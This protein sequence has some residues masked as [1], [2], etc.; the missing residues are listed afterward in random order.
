MKKTKT[1]KV[2]VI[3]P[4]YNGAETIEQTVSIILNS[5][6]QNLEILLVDD[7]SKDKS[8]EVCRKLQEKDKRVLVL[9][10]ENGGVASARN[11]GV[12]SA[13][14][15]YLCFCDQDD[16]V[17]AETYARMIARMEDE[18]SDICICGTGRSVEGQ[19]SAFELSED[20][21][22]EGKSISENLIYPIVFKG[23]N[24]PVKMS[25]ISRYPTIWNCMFRR[26]FWDKYEFQFRSYVNFEDDL[27]LKLDALSRA[28]RVSSIAYTG[29]YWNVNLKSET[30]AHKFVENLAEKQQLYYEDME[31][32]VKRCTKEK[33][34]LL[35]F[36]QVMR[37]K[38]YL[39]AIHILTS[40]QKK[41]DLAYIRTFCKK[42]IF[43]KDF[44][45]GIS[46]RKYVAKGQI[47]AKV[48]LPLLAKKL[49]LTSYMTEKVLDYVLWIS[50]HSQILTKLERKLKGK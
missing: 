6:Y 20:A 48:L 41:K 30:Y 4:V 24:V 15:E 16:F 45:A 43:E 47:R 39:D 17:E 34:I 12:A 5:T 1:G 19:K 11:F 50:L 44:A 18:I 27:L 32:S 7:G 42:T 3:V 35:Y 31:C 9:Q 40:P 38:L 21:F 22:Y 14:G 49:S 10:K 25:S 37:C 33:Q 2:S 28:E 13:T 36:K 29:Y 23:F 26:T 8:L 46:A